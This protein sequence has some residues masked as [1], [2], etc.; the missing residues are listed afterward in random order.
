MKKV[1]AE[2]PEITKQLEADRRQHINETFNKL[3]FNEIMKHT[4]PKHDNLHNILNDIFTSIQQ[5]T[6][7]NTTNPSVL[8]SSANNS[9]DNTGNNNAGPFNTAAKTERVPIYEEYFPELFVY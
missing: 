1:L 8:I 2:P 3:T 6:I 4:Q 5:P 9:F 7:Q